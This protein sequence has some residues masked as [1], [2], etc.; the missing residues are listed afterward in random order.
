MNQF[1]KQT[2]NSRFGAMGDRAEQ[3]FDEAHPKHHKL[4][5]NRPPFSMA[6]MSAAMRY[7]PDR[8]TRH[9]FVEVMGIGRDRLLKVKDEKVEALLEWATIAPVDLF[10]YDQ[11]SQCTY[12][13]PLDRWVEALS[14]YGIDGM[15]GEG[16]TYKAL[17]VDHFPYCP[18]PRIPSAAA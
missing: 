7:V 13:G 9:A 1:H 15:F 6:G 11:S 4:G 10:V 2:F 17:S 12:E 18:T 3:V 8:M 14:T 16:K 5:L